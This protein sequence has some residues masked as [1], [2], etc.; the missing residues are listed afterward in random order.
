MIT[1]EHIKI[2]VDKVQDEYLEALY[3]IVKVFEYPP[4]KG[5][6]SQIDALE[7]TLYATESDWIAFVNETYGCLANDPIERGEQGT[8]EFRETIE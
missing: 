4:G 7:P 2:E 8:Y 5:N 6:S 3:R 1:R